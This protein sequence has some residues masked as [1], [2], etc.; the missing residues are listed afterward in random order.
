MLA[1]HVDYRKSLS[2]Q[3]TLYNIFSRVLRSFTKDGLATNIASFTHN[4]PYMHRSNRDY[5]E[6]ALNPKILDKMDKT[7]APLL[8]PEWAYLRPHVQAAFVYERNQ[9]D[10]ALKQNTK[11]LALMTEDNKPDGR[12]VVMVLQ[13]CI[14]WQLGR[15]GEAKEAMET[16][17]A[18]VNAAAPYFIP[19]L[20]AYRATR[21]LL[22]GD[23]S[24]AR[25]WLEQYYVT[26]IDHIE[27]FLSFQHFTTARAYAA[28]GEKERA[29]EYLL[30]LKDFGINLNRPLDRCE[31]GVILA[32]FYQAQNQKKEADAELTEVLEVLQP[33]G[34]IR[35][36][37]DE[38]RVIVP[39]LKRIITTVAE[40]G[41]K[42]PLT[43][44]YV[45]E[46]MLA[47]HSFGNAHGGYM[48]GAA[49]KKEK[50]VKLSGQQSHMLILLS[51][52]YRQA[53]ISAETGLSIPTIKSHTSLA[54]KKLGVNNAMDAVLKA[55]ELGLIE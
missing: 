1:F 5:S 47:A 37:A 32:A 18:F 52:G 20:T 19:N 45:N 15:Y 40:D 22:D 31:A 13:H 29:L 23:I 35:V 46:V 16:L 49:K 50:P 2:Q 54:Y 14:L 43:R 21:R 48:A 9:L 38:G 4:L 25:E 10:A 51:K 24:A 55:R 11:I 6:I 39:V 17:T 30:L 42:G 41:Y 3:V 34:F 33:Y 26:D 36:V 44:A 7:Y 28:L 27:F 8:G 12:I 53:D